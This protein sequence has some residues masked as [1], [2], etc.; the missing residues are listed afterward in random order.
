MGEVTFSQAL[1]P[2]TACGSLRWRTEVENTD[3]YVTVNTFRLCA[4][5]L[6]RMLQCAKKPLQSTRCF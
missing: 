1:P 6:V 2:N 5:S 3:K 4:A